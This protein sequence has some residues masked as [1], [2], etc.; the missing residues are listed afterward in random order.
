MR[1]TGALAAMLQ[2]SSGALL[3][4]GLPTGTLVAAPRI[5]P[6]RESGAASDPTE[7]MMPS[8]CMDSNRSRSQPV[9]RARMAELEARIV[10]LESAM[11]DV[12]ENGMRGKRF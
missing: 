7:T 11:L 9:W 10:N 3:L 2:V 6:L 5:M 1:C 4:L 8:H 12:E